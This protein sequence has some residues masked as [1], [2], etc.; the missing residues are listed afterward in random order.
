M[1]QLFTPQLELGATPIA[2]IT[3]NPRSRD[4]IPQILLGLQHIYCKPSLRDAVFEVLHNHLSQKI[5]F[6]NGRPGMDLWILL[7]LGTLRLGLNC[8]YDRLHELANE[9]RTVRALLGHG[10]WQDNYQYALQTLKDNVV[11]L[12]EEMLLEINTIVVSAGVN[13]TV[14]APLFAGV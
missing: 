3:F 5:D 14:K 13:A 9:H 6:N 2:E 11:L 4:D 12:T 8:D 10:D 1:R 7:V